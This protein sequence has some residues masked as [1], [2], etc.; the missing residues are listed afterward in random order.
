MVEV[1]KE[2]DKEVMDNEIG[3]KVNA[4]GILV[5]VIFFTHLTREV[6]N[7]T[8]SITSGV[9]LACSP[10]YF[11]T[12]LNHQKLG[13]KKYFAAVKRGAVGRNL[14]FSPGTWNSSPV[15]QFYAAQCSSPSVDVFSPESPFWGGNEISTPHRTLPAPPQWTLYTPHCTLL[16]AHCAMQT[17]HCALRLNILHII[18][19]LRKSSKPHSTLFSETWVLFD[20]RTL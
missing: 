19:T 9:D 4:P 6:K 12:W 18:H 20:L 14:P 7:C 17:A 5:W 16:T 2:F 3:E 11:L 13:R 8:F 1:E 15:L 10:D